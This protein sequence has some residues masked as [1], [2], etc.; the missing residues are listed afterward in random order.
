[1]KDATGS[2]CWRIHCHMSWTCAYSVQIS[3]P[4]HSSHVQ[5]GKKSCCYRSL[6]TWRPTR[7]HTHTHT[8]LLS[9][10]WCRL[11]DLQKPDPN[12]MHNHYSSPHGGGNTMKRIQKNV[13]IHLL[14]LYSITSSLYPVQLIDSKLILSTDDD[15]NKRIMA[16]NTF[17]GVLTALGTE[18]FSAVVMFSVKSSVCGT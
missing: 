16:A 18:I 4:F 1:M 17:N 12:A 9:C 11:D 13:E 3:I 8:I 10:L 7:A 2:W 14:L 6:P 15:W 5:H